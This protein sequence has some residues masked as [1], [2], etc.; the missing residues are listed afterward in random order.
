ME[1]KSKPEK[2]AGFPTD[3]KLEYKFDRIIKSI[4]G[5]QFIAKDI[6]ADL[7][8]G[9]DFLVYSVLPIR[10]ACRLRRF[11]YVKY[12]SE[13]TI[14]WSR[15]SGIATEFHKVMKGLVNYILYGFVDEHEEKIVRYFIG[16]LNVFV[17]S[18][19]K[20]YSIKPNVPY[21]SELAIYRISDFPGNFVVKTW[22]PNT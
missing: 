20:P 9:T 10:V 3:S 5:N 16:D 2:P 13:F 21:D 11:K 19:I 6:T 22:P 8:E 17:E 4:L 7:N 1:T 14:R 12:D 15:P 18:N